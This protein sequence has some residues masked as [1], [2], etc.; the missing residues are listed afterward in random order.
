[1]DFNSFLLSLVG[2]GPSLGGGPVSDLHFR[3]GLPPLLRVNGELLP[4]RFNAMKPDDTEKIARGLV[5]QRGIDLDGRNEID[6]AY[7]IPGRARFRVNVFR[8]QGH[9]AVVLRVIND[10][11]PTVEQLRLPPIVKEIALEHR[12][13]VL[14]TGITGSGKSST[15]A[16]MIN[17]VNAT[18]QAHVLT[19]EDPIEYVY[20]PQRCTVSQ[21]EVGCDTG[22]FAD[23]LRAALRQD[24]DVI[25]VGEMRD[26]ET[27]SIAIKAAETGH[28]VFSTLHTVDAS[29]TINRIVDSFPAEQQQQVRLQLAANLQ[30][31]I[32]QRLLPARAGGRL[33]AVEVMRT[34]AMIRDCIEHPEK[35]AHIRDAI[36]QGRDQYGMQLFD[37][38][39]RD[40]YQQELIDLDT[41]MA[42][43]TSPADFQRALSFE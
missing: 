27:I 15:L 31:I 33:P 5:S 39:L 25:L 30:A 12:G 9:H 18:R 28:L 42:A 21:R 3:V 2:L 17:H 32:S 6:T 14:V 8:E 16:A 38:H 23:A 29:K 4:A 35:T 24:P 19:I 41:A 13:M 1:M 26:P 22:S 43:A 7:A 37:Q 10:V 36:A 40:L 20:V 11:I 34:T